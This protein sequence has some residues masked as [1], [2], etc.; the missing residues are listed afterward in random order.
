LE[1]FMN[2]FKI[3]EIDTC[4]DLETVALVQQLQQSVTPTEVIAVIQNLAK[5]EKRTAIPPLIEALSHQHPSV[6]IKAVEALVQL[7]PDSVEPLIAAFCV[8]RDHGVQAYIVQALAQIGDSRS[9]ELLVEVVGVEVANHCQGNVRRV[10]ARGLGKIGATVNNPQITQQ[11]VDKL[12]WAVLKAEDWALRYASAV[13]LQEIATI[14]AQTALQQ[15][16]T[17]EREKVVQARINTALEALN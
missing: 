15:A 3:D 10:A 4:S 12:T 6:P 17:Q 14:E 9:L 13:S 8:S 11:A 1:F 7:A 16:L 5:S 2:P